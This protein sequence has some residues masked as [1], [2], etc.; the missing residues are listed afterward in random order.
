MNKSILSVV[1]SILL[2]IGMATAQSDTLVVKSY[3]GPDFEQASEIIPCASGGYALVGTTGS[4]QSGNTDVFVARIDDELNCVWSH[5]FGG[6]DVE[7][8]LSIVEDWSGN[9]L[10]CGYTSS[11]GAGSYDMLVMKV[12]ATGDLMWQ[13]SFGGTDWDFGKKIIAHPQGGYLL[14]GNT[15]SNGNGAQDGTIIHLDGQGILL[16]QWFVGGVQ[17]D[18][19]HDLLA[20]SDGWFACGYQTLNDTMKASVWRFDLS[21]NQIWNRITNDVMGYGREAFAMSMDTSFLYL[22]GSVYTEGVTRSFEQQLA[23]DNSV[24]YEVIEQESFDVE[25]L[26]CSHYNGEIVYVGSKSLSGI[27]LGRVVRKRNDTFFTGAFEFTG[28]HRARFTCSHWDE[29]ALVLCGSFQPVA[30]QNWQALVVKYVSRNLNEVS[31]EPEF[32]PCFSVGIEELSE[33]TP[34]MP[35]AVYNVQGQ[36]VLSNV[37]WH[38]RTDSF[39]LAKGCY[40]FRSN[41]GPVRRFVVF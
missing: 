29:N 26:D 12:N 32:L 10:V 30:S 19:V 39:G 17:T 13:Q 6:S 7:W 38:P 35:G 40:V 41:A 18:G 8:G 31:Q 33:V 1:F 34:G 27:E 2:S 15:Y 28:Q 4:N 16:N 21:G 3:G 5:N 24:N 22:T 25:Y 11:A 23:L 37:D 36:L 9:F 14:C 20:V